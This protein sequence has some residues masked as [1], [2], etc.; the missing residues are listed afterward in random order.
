MD[1][2]IKKQ[3]ETKNYEILT[4][5]LKI[6]LNNNSDSLNKTIENIV[7]LHL[8]KLEK[9][10]ANILKNSDT[11]ND[12]NK[13]NE[14]FNEEKDIL[15]TIMLEKVQQRRDVILKFFEKDETA[16]FLEKYFDT[17]DQSRKEFDEQIRSTLNEEILTSFTNKIRTSCTFKDEEGKNVVTSIIVSGL[18]QPLIEGASDNNE[19]RSNNL[20]N[21]AKDS[22]NYY[23]ELNRV[24]TDTYEDDELVKEKKKNIDNIA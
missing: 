3:F 16:E 17:I 10:L 18:Q 13:I 7:D 19:L 14:Y 21:F 4:N 9:S 24:T 1:E 12:S 8:T 5:K 2:S 11:A 23:L 6:D 20:K 22:Y 15:K